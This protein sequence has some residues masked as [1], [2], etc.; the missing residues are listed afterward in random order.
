MT[1]VASFAPVSRDRANVEC[2]DIRP[3]EAGRNI[4]QRAIMAARRLTVNRTAMSAPPQE[5]RREDIE[6]GDVEGDPLY[7][8]SSSSIPAYV[9]FLCGYFGPEVP[10]QLMDSRPWVFGRAW[11]LIVCGNFTQT[12]CFFLFSLVVGWGC[13]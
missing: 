8:H 10:C 5:S 1:I 3:W 2:H 11:V 4:A 7:E 12:F 13:D 9:R 6:A